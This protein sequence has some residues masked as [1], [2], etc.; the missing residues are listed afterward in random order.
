MVSNHVQSQMCD[1]YCN[2]RGYAA[3][4]L[5]VQ[6]LLM[7]NSY[8]PPTVSELHQHAIEFEEMLIRL[9]WQGPMLFCGD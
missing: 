1:E 6:D 7:I 5:K 9:D 4:A 8:C 2:K 3:I